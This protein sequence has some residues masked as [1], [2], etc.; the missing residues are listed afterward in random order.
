MQSRDIRQAE[1]RSIHTNDLELLFEAYDREFFDGHCR[2]ALAGRRLD[3][4]LSPRM[5]TRRGHTRRVRFAYW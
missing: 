5:T 3:F 4:R 1:F 2:A